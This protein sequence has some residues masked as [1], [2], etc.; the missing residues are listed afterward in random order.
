MIKLYTP[1]DH[2]GIPTQ[3]VSP[4]DATE[5]DDLYVEYAEH[6]AA[7]MPFGLSVT[8]NGADV[9]MHF[10]GGSKKGSI[11]L[12]EITGFTPIVQEAIRTWASRFA[13]AKDSNHGI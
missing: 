5:D 1:E 2:R 8:R 9:W 7:A 11:N 4:N 12:S 13:P 10:D 6:K 3:M